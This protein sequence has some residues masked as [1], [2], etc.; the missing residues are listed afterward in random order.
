MLQTYIIIIYRMQFMANVVEHFIDFSKTA[1]ET[2]F[3]F[4]QLT[5]LNVSSIGNTKQLTFHHHS[6]T[7][8]F[9]LVK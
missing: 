6:T 1:L 9:A 5:R 3:F 4:T 8:D 2:V 7:I